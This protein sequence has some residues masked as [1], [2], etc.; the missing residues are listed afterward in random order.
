MWLQGLASSERCQVK[1]SPIPT[2]AWTWLL[3]GLE[4][5]A[6]PT[7]RLRTKVKPPREMR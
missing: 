5:T 7:P 1:P 6:Y 3:I 2:N 4:V